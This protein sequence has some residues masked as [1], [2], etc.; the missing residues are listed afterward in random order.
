VITLH[1]AADRLGVHYMTVYRY[2]RTGRLPAVKEGAEW[3][4]DAADVDALRAV[5]TT[6][7]QHPSPRT[8]ARDRL[9]DRLV[10]GDEPGAWGVVEAALA[11]GAD[12]ADIHLKLVAPALRSIGRRWEAGELGVGDE[13]RGSAVARRLV[14]R[15]G[16]RFARRGRKRGTV[17]VGAIAGERHD[18]PVAI[19]ADLLRGARFEVVDLGADTPADSLATAAARHRPVAVLLGITATGRE[20]AVV[21][22]V[23][24]VH[25][26]APVTVLV[27]GA[28]IPSAAAARALGADGW[29]GLD[30]LAAVAAVEALVRA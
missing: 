7:P 2:I 8:W 11:S 14:A 1:E 17:V 25:A 22:A 21:T 18:I 16:P 27:G 30:A 29:T 28:A 9:E 4:V 10:A 24:V 3:R 19:V 5:A 23:R 13:H 26:A 6:P 15:L 12:P 20:P